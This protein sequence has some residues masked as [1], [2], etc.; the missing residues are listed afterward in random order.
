MKTRMFLASAVAPTLTLTL[1]ISLVGPGRLGGAEAAKLPSCAPGWDVAVVA[2]APRV[3]HPT[4][5]AGSPDGRVFVCED[6]MDMAGP[7]DRPVNRLLCVHPDG[8]ITVFADRIYAVFGMEYI[9]GKLYVHHSPRFSVFTDGGEVGKDRVDLIET[10]NPAPWGSAVRGK[11]Q[12]NDHAPAG[13]ALGMDGY[14]Y[15]AVG[16]K[17]IYGMVGRDGRRLELPLG[18]VIRM[19][20]D[21]TGLETF[22][23]GFRTVLNPAL[24]AEGAI[25]LYDNNDH[26]NFHKVAVG[27]V[28]DGGY[29][30][31]PWDYRPPRPGYV[32]PM[33]LRVYAGGAPTGILAYEEDSLP[34]MYQ[35][36][37]FLCDWGRQEVVRLSIERRGAGYRVVGEEKVLQG[38]IRPT[39]IAISPDGMSF[40][41]GDWQFP[42]WREDVPV[43][44][45]IKL[46]YRG[47]SR[48]APK[49]AWY[50]PAAM[51]RSFQATTR[52][53]IEA[54]RHRS[55]SVRMIAQRRLA[56]R[57]P[58][59]VASLIR[60][61]HD[62]AEP[63]TARWHAIWALDALDGGSSGRDAILKAAG[64]QDPSVRIQAIRQL[65]TRH[66]GQARDVFLAHLADPDAAVRLEAAIAVGRLGVVEAVAELRDRLA[67]DDPLVRYAA[68]TALNR[69]G[70]AQPTAWAEVVSGLASDREMVREGT[71]FAL[72]ETYDP[73]LIAALVRFARHLSLPG[74]VRAGAYRTLL[75]MGHQPPEWDGLWW[76]LGPLGYI[77]DSHDV[78]PS[79][80]KTRAWEGTAAV[81]EALYQAL[82]DVDPHVRRTAVAWAAHELDRGT[83]ARL[84]RLFDDP[85]LAADRAAILHALGTASDS[86]AVELIL[87]VLRQPGRYTGLIPDAVAAARR[88]GGLA[89]SEALTRLAGA[90]IPP[91]SLTVALEA[92]GELRVAG[93][94]PTLRSRL[95]HRELE[96]RIAATR[97][98]AQIGGAAAA[99]ALLPS[100]DDQEVRLR[101]EVVSALGS[102]RVKS[103][104]PGLLRAYRDPQTRLEAVAALARV[105]DPRALDA[106]L[107]GIVA[108][109]PRV[110]EDC[111]KAL[112]TI[113]GAARPLIRQKLA[114]GS[115]TDPVIAELKSIY[116]DDSAL[117]PLLQS[118]RERPGPRDY[119]AFA[120]AN[121]G[122]PRRGR[123]IFTD[124]RGVGCI[125]CHRVRGVGG[126]GGPDL[127]HVA[128]N[129]GRKEFI[130]SI[131][132]PSQKVAAG[133]RL[134][135]IGTTDGMILSGVVLDEKG[136]RVTLADS[137]GQKQVIR[138]SDIDQR[139]ESDASAMPEGLQAGLT[140]EEFADLVA[141]LESLK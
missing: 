32:L 40:Y 139:T 22:A 86:A 29:Y 88:Q 58:A 52:E 138:K 56:E 70:R 4:A 107:D 109:S 31:Y 96:V 6:R 44:R 25:F 117:A 134:T 45:L 63:H 18:G 72:R 3:L 47:T 15:I 108:R 7:V 75:A 69:I 42:G 85:E 112:A 33:D 9:D 94:I 30:G 77:E 97:A 128:T 64:D 49:P 38:A 48:A 93:A 80:P 10:T 19:R 83:V 65:G 116:G 84:V 113:A 106:Y 16:D 91:R 59:A 66:V 132:A 103:A 82:D 136:D 35:G 102:L 46:T 130:E 28:V 26:L 62:P 39:G 101:R 92:L 61:V 60:L 1:L 20:P 17:G 89:M 41:V 126:E 118:A 14:L 100:L 23:T 131:L 79:L 114:S 36:S 127:T 11:N 99:E 104:V 68:F 51:G 73:S 43:G 95:T 53:L 55:R 81:I 120:L 13:F 57:G 110:R 129:Y 133:F 34:E 71:M 124:P 12:I 2:A 8:R 78:R 24:N 5:V 122:D 140:L 87:A 27:L 21:A 67:D 125:K 37:L 90:E 123:S 111:R 141:Y 74:P 76:R 50:V 119:L 54:L 115:L 121:R 137:Q 105:P 135:T 98:L